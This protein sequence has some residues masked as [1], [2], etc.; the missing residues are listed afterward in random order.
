M[1]TMAL[2]WWGEYLARG[3]PPP[4]PFRARSALDA[5][6]YASHRARSAAAVDG[7]S[8][9]APGLWVG[10]LDDAEPDELAPRGITTVVTALNIRGL[11]SMYPKASGVAHVIL[12]VE[13]EPDADIGA[14]FAAAHAAIRSAL[15]ARAA[16]AGGGVLVHCMQGRSRSVAL[17][18]AHLVAEGS[19]LDAAAARVVAARA[20]ASPNAGFV[21]RLRAFEAHCRA[22]RDPAEFGRAPPPPPPR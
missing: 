5:A 13:D 1:T 11:D 22:G 8:E 3:A 20:V 4:D 18:A 14:H 6:D 7:P 21:R 19:T 15:A 10:S 16:G 9:V 2:A 17:V 12:P